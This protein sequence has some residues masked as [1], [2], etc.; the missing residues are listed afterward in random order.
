MNNQKSTVTRK[1]KQ[2]G[3]ETALV[4]KIANFKPFVKQH[5]YTSV[6]VNKS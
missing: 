1:N 3:Q 5:N 2:N 4:T 6:N